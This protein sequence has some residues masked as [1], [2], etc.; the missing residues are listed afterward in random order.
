MKY[1]VF[2]TLIF[3]ALCVN[4]HGQTYVRGDVSGTW[5]KAN[6]PYIVEN[7]ITIQSNTIL[8]ICGAW[9]RNKI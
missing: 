3:F 4:L 5:T 6:S 2:S 1:F 8:T 9:S 7:T